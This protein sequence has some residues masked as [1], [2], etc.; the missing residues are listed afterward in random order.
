MGPGDPIV[1]LGTMVSAFQ[2]GGLYLFQDDTGDPSPG[3]FPEFLGKGY[4]GFNTSSKKY[5][6]FWSD[7]ASTMMQLEKG[8]VDASGKIWTMVSSFQHPS[9]GQTMSKRSVIRLIDQDHKI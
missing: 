3:P 6:G 4:W 7:N 8:D 2:L 5:E 9:S 1:Q